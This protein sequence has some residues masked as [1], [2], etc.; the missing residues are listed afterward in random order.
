M[1]PLKVAERSF[2]R[3]RSSERPSR[4]S[5]QGIADE[6]GPLSSGAPG[7]KNSAYDCRSNAEACD[8]FAREQIPSGNSA[9][10]VNGI[11]HDGNETNGG[12]ER[13]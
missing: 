1:I 6:F 7:S 8:L 12:R 11:T 2:W 13:S 10:D 4:D 5:A 9:D 3:V